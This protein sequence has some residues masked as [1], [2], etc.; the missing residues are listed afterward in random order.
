MM[1]RT[2]EPDAPSCAR[3]GAACL[4]K[5][6]RRGGEAVHAMAGGDLTIAAG[7]ALRVRGRVPPVTSWIATQA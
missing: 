5:T 4:T 7:A 6:Y 3:V 1:M 2:R